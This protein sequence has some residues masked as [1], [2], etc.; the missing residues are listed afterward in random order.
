MGEQ[1]RSRAE[2]VLA[3]DVREAGQTSMPGST[4]RHSW[5]AAGRDDVAVGAEHGTGEPGQST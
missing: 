3:Q 1:D 4:T 5:P 2:P